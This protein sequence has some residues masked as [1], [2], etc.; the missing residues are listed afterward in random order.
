ML[1]IQ[2]PLLEGTT[3]NKK[4]G[5]TKNSPR[6]K[7]SNSRKA[8]SGN[9]ASDILDG[10]D[11]SQTIMPRIW[12]IAQLL[13]YTDAFMRPLKHVIPHS[14]N[15]CDP[16]KYTGVMSKR[17][18]R[19]FPLIYVKQKRFVS[20]NWPHSTSFSSS[21]RILNYTVKDSRINLRNITI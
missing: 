10:H 2:I 15:S 3:K 21:F 17:T 9:S 6:Y 5:S 14:Y 11:V 4:N 13:F 1:K 19:L 16:V 8:C 20:K 7:E 18:D 12:H